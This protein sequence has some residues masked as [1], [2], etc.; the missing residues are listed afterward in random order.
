VE[1]LWVSFETR[2]CAG[3]APRIW[4]IFQIA[5]TAPG[6]SWVDP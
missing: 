3:G 4:R 2:L 5:D 1:C 6:G